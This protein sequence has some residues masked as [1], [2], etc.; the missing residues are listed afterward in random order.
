MSR[1]W[2][3]V[4]GVIGAIAAGCAAGPNATAE[5]E[6]ALQC[7]PQRDTAGRAS[8][9][10]SALVQA[11]ELQAKICYGRPSAKGRNMIGGELVPYGKL[12]RTGAN[13]PTIIHLAT[14]AEI[15]GIALEPGS[16]SLYTIPEAESWTVIVNRAIAQWGHESTYREEVEAQ[17]V[18]RATVAR[19]D[20]GEHVETFTIRSEAADAGGAQIVLEWETTR[21]RI[22][23][24]AH[25]H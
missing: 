12:W 25:Q 6:V 13:E 3:L 9:Y 11:G 8:P 15:A 2:M 5:Q 23:I 14:S 18:G 22:P 19:E 21:V 17:E 20:L 7:A 16:Y 10:D 1:R 4:T 24:S